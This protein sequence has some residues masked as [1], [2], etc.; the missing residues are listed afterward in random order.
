MPAGFLH[1]LLFLNIGVVW[2][3]SFADVIEWRIVGWLPCKAAVTDA[4]GETEAIV[5]SIFT[6]YESELGLPIERYKK[7]IRKA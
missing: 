4:Y 7:V 5:K 3:F 6:A 1:C 2:P